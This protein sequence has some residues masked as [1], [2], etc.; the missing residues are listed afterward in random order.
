MNRLKTVGV[1]LAT[2]L[3]VALA[4]GS[5]SA[6]SAQGAGAG[7][8]RVV[9]DRS[10]AADVFD[11]TRQKLSDGACVCYIYTGPHSQSQAVEGNIASVVQSR[12]C[13]AARAMS[14]PGEQAAGAGLGHSGWLVGAAG[15][16]GGVAYG[17]SK[18]DERVSP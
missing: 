3:L 2:S 12:S 18:G 16:V 10:Q 4:A 11:V 13:P 17:V 8:C 1:S 9:V 15:L 14:V 7:Q 5:A 6:A